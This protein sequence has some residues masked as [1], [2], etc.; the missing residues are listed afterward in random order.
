MCGIVGAIALSSNGKGKLLDTSRALFSDLVLVDELRGRDST[1]I[2]LGDPR[3]KN[4]SSAPVFK[5]AVPA[6][7]FL[8][9]KAAKELIRK[10]SEYGFAIGHNRAA[11][12]GAI[13]NKNS[14]P[15]RFGNITLVHNGTLTSVENLAKTGDKSLDTVDSARI[16]KTISEIHPSPTK[17]VEF[18]ESLEGAYTLIWYDKNTNVMWMCRNSER[19]LSYGMT[20]TTAYIASEAKMLEWVFS[21]HFRFSLDVRTLPTGELW[22]WDLN[23]DKKSNLKD[24]VVKYDFKPKPYTSGFFYHGVYHGTNVHV[25]S[26]YNGGSNVTPKDS[27]NNTILKDIDLKVGDIIEFYPYKFIPFSTTSLYGSMEGTYWPESGA[28]ANKAIT[29]KVYGLKAEEGEKLVEKN[30]L[31]GSVESANRAV[32]SGPNTITIILRKETVSAVA[33]LQE[34]NDN[35]EEDTLEDNWCVWCWATVGE[36]EELEYYAINEEG[37]LMCS[38]CLE[39]TKTFDFDILK[40]LQEEVRK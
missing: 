13:N 3:H 19:P 23:S 21:R 37:D 33:D 25:P 34:N 22:K 24:F 18:L 28:S 38:S 16:A 27:F 26:K 2:F 31:R 5:R 12:K 17:Y 32:V 6:H 29:V 9:D 10:S 1:G 11:T 20:T 8:A 40:Q 36:D 30:V 7:E 4:M 35:K 39:D 15:F 14:H